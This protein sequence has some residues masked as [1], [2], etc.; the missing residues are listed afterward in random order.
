[1]ILF[2]NKFKF[3]YCRY[4]QKVEEKGFDLTIEFNKSLEMYDLVH[5]IILEL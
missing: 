4:W 2:N 1:M 3:D 5:F